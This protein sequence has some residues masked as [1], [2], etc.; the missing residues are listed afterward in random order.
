MR[1]SDIT[2][3]AL[4]TI[5]NFDYCALPH[6]GPYANAWLSEDGGRR[7][8]YLPSGTA[9]VLE[10]TKAPEGFIKADPILVKVGE[11]HE[12]QQHEIFNE[13]KALAVSKRSSVTGKELAGAE[14]VL[15]KADE[16]G[17]LNQ[18]EPYLIDSW[19]SGTD[20][21]YTEKDFINGLIPEGFAEGDLKP[22]TL[23]HLSEGYYYLTEQKAPAYYQAAVPV[24]FITVE[25]RTKQYR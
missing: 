24:K 15:Y 10:E 8:D 23:L 9:Y 3:A 12:I 18:T 1:I 7:I 17:M 25:R 2:E 20:G 22:H 6:V 13:K 4:N 16:H 11:E 21:V 19:I 5:I 14:L